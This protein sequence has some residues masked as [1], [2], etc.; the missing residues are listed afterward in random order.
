MAPWFLGK[1]M[2]WSFLG[3]EIS[4]QRDYSEAV[5]EKIDQE[6]KKMVNEAYT[7]AKEILS[8]YRGKLDEVAGRLLEVETLSKEEFDKIFTPPVKKNQGIPKM[9]TE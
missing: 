1:R 9:A 5:A 4:E 3:R 6:V 7:S 2:N 8:K